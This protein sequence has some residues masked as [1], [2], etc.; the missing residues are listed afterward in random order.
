M[1]IAGFHTKFYAAAAHNAS[2]LQQ[3]TASL[4]WQ[5]ANFLK[6]RDYRDFKVSE[7]WS[8]LCFDDLIKHCSRMETFKDVF[9]QTL[10]E[11]DVELDGLYNVKNDMREITILS[12]HIL[13]LESLQKEF[14]KLFTC[15]RVALEPFA[16][17]ECDAPSGSFLRFLKRN[18]KWT[19]CVN[20]VVKEWKK[21]HPTTQENFD[22][23]SLPIDPECQEGIPLVEIRATGG[24]SVP[25]KKHQLGKERVKFLRPPI[26]KVNIEK[27]KKGKK[28]AVVVEKASYASNDSNLRSFSSRGSTS[29]F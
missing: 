10:D 18:F 22:F 14:R 17:I 29:R 8:A 9:K 24:P 6:G 4:Q 1:L 12:Q 19:P 21:L 5:Y 7:N 27:I 26:P 23:P 3:T 25:N 2:Y 13:K 16:E 11:H 28:K 20:K 15:F